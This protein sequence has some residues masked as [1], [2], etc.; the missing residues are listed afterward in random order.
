MVEDKEIKMSKSGDSKHESPNVPKSS[1]IRWGPRLVM[2]W[3]APEKLKEIGV[4]LQQWFGSSAFWETVHS[5][6]KKWI[7][8]HP[9]EHYI[10]LKLTPKSYRGYLIFFPFHGRNWSIFLHCGENNGAYELYFLKFRLNSQIY[11]GTWWVVELTQSKTSN[12]HWSLWLED[13]WFMKGQD[14]RGMRPTERN[15]FARQQ[16]V[17]NW[18]PDPAIESVELKWKPTCMGSQFSAMLYFLSKQSH[19]DIT[20]IRFWFSSNNENKTNRNDV[21]QVYS[22]NGS[23]YGFEK[24]FHTLV[25]KE[26][27]IILQEEQSNLNWNPSHCI[28]AC[29][30]TTNPDI[31]ELSTMDREGDHGIAIG[32]ACVPSIQVSLN[33]KQL[34]KDPTI[35]VLWVYC[36]WHN[37]FGRWV[38]LRVATEKERQSR[39]WKNLPEGNPPKKFWLPKNKW[40]SLP[41]PDLE[42][43]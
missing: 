3:E 18:Q 9:E 35:S 43:I 12:E 22:W 15:Q 13:C 34:F 27:S 41:V 32:R 11:Q 37:W 2:R 24:T 7:Y 36:E 42:S 25:E 6:D 38:P 39:K 33:L 20:N 28:H 19:L 31:Y 4:H 26:Q 5:I 23:I 1:F 10:W 17:Q 16:M 29:W 14:L 21:L 8:D 30:K 40:Y